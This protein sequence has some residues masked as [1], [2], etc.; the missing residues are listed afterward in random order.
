M[1]INSSEEAKRGYELIQHLE[2]L[3]TSPQWTEAVVK[4]SE[5]VEFVAARAADQQRPIPDDRQYCRPYST[6]R[7]PK[8]DTK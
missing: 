4:V 2:T 6:Q 1:N 3:G 5:Y 8:G 7:T